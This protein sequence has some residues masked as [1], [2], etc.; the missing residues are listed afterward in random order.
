MVGPCTAM[1]IR[2]R[3]LILILSVLLPAFVAAVLAV[4]YVYLE[5]RQ[6]QENSVKEAVRA[7][8]LLVDN[9]FEIKEGVL[10]TLAASPALARGDLAE[11]YRT[12]KPLTSAPDTIVILHDANGRQLLNTRV[13]F[14]ARLPDRR[15]SDIGEL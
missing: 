14:G 3:L 10:R 11:F 15:S 2:T 8:A 4:S 12:A 7:F 6:A 1:R 9:E 13:P 5:E